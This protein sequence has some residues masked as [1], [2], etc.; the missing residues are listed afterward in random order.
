[1]YNSCT[2][3]AAAAA[4][5]GAGAAAKQPAEPAQTKKAEAKEAKETKKEEAPKHTQEQIKGK[6][7][8]EL[9]EMKYKFDSSDENDW[10]A[11][12]ERQRGYE[13]EMKQSIE[14]TEKIPLEPLQEGIT[15]VRPFL[16]STFKDFNEERNICFQTSFPR[17]EKL[18]NDRGMLFA[19]LDLRWGV[20]GEQSGSGQVIKICL[21]EVDRS[22]P[23][24]VCSLGFRNGWALGPD[25][26][27]ENGGVVLLKKTFEIGIEAFPWIDNMWDRSVTEIEILHGA[28]ND[29]KASPRCFFYFRSVDFIDK[30]VPKD[31]RWMYVEMGYPEIKLLDL[32][33]RII[34]A[35]F[36][37]RFFDDP[38]EQATIL[39]EDLTAS[40]KSDFPIGR[41]SPLENEL[42]DNQASAEMRTRVYVGGEQYMT[43]LD[44]LLQSEES[45]PIVLVG[46]SGSGKSACIANWMARVR[47]RAKDSE[48][49]GR[50]FKD[51][52]AA[53]EN[54]NKKDGTE[55]KEEEKEEIQILSWNEALFQDR[56]IGSTSDSTYAASLIR[57]I[58]QEIKERYNLTEKEVPRDNKKVIEE[59][60]AW[61]EDASA[62]APLLLVLD[63]LDQMADPDEHYLNWLPT[64]FPKAMRVIFSTTPGSVC[65]ATLKERGYDM[66]EVNPL[67]EDECL[68]LI[69]NFLSMFGKNLDVEQEK[70]IMGCPRTRNPL[71]LSTFLQEVRVFGSYEGLNERIDHYMSSEN[72]TE[73]FLKVIGRLEKDFDNADLALVR[74]TLSFLMVSRRGLNESE[75][76]GC[77]KTILTAAADGKDEKPFPTMEFSALMLQLDSSLVDQRGVKKFSHDYLKDAVTSKY[78]PGQE[79]AKFKPTQ[80]RLADYFKSQSISDRKVEELPHHLYSMCSSY[81]GSAESKASIDE[82]VQALTELS[83]VVVDLDMFDVLKSQEFKWDLHKYWQLIEGDKAADSTAAS[84]KAKIEAWKTETTPEPLAYAEKCEDVGTFLIS[85]D[86][87][88]GADQFLDSALEIRKKEQGEDLDVIEQLLN[89]KANLLHR[90]LM[91]DEALPLY[92]QALKIVEKP[93]SDEDLKSKVLSAPGGDWEAFQKLDEGKKKEKKDELIKER[94]IRASVLAT[95]IAGLLK[96]QGKYD[97][98]MPMYERSLKEKIDL[99]GEFD[100][101]VAVSMNN[102]ADL[103][104]RLKQP[105]KALPL[106]EK[107]MNVMQINL[108]RSH[109][110]MATLLSSLA[111]AH[112]QQGKHEEALELYERARKIKEKLMGENH[113]SVAVV[114]NN[115]AATYQIAAQKG[116]K[117]EKDAKYTKAFDLYQRVL[118]IRIATYGE[119]NPILSPTLINIASIHQAQKTNDKAIECYQ[120]AL[121]S[122][123][124]SAGS[125]PMDLTYSIHQIAK[126]YMNTDKFNEAIEQYKRELEILEANEK[127]KAQ[128]PNLLSDIGTVY[129]KLNKYKEAL[130][131]YQ[132]ELK[133]LEAELEADD[134]KIADKLVIIGVVYVSDEDGDDDNSEKAKE[135]FQRAYDIRVKKFGEESQEALDVKGWMDDLNDEDMDLDE[136][137]DEDLGDTDDDDDAE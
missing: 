134:P 94:K 80:R 36:G 126:I 109:P 3:P 46:T 8:E 117:S 60:P 102:L 112:L 65:H 135:A 98:A 81:D 64:T 34:Q 131:Y 63:G 127:G 77:L 122:M 104:L 37:I 29:P 66:L 108:G 58:M 115:V 90:Q 121:K 40:I 136:D 113:I 95:S 15:Y 106:Y 128:I 41:Y 18:C 13:K 25:D 21:E 9:V 116:D 33:R 39:E 67:S 22:R 103:Y 84:Y 30:Y 114:L 49:P 97:E 59:F 62:R 79:T 100:S 99:L 20:T 48:F 1:M 50:P 11:F 87:Y 35:G 105:E 23:Y 72:I 68:S 45:K 75:L 28:L 43:K 85:T 12:L 57:W 55:L 92:K 27:P 42:K 14:T 86:R 74:H 91:F 137:D 129:Q 52:K 110:M 38:N 6:S 31:K 51:W 118:N 125:S 71:F 82:K 54:Q 5:A 93:P 130:P 7:L 70:R 78:F 61:L 119:D 101:M 88:K 120:K 2:Q 53:L 17:L 56:Y 32:K 132:R 133:L 10:K 76:R 96:E 107:A 83:E 24:F 44:A 47:K 16:S 26:D 123:E 19:P 89:K 124:S 111:S 73:M 4:G 69:R